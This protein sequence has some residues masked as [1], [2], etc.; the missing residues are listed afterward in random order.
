LENDWHRSLNGVLFMKRRDFITLLSGA[1][2]AWPLMAEAQ[3][4]GK[5]LITGRLVGGD[6]A[7]RGR[8][9]PALLGTEHCSD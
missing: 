3:Q 7:R 9:F 1:A 6:R 8:L 2:A 4:H 5:L